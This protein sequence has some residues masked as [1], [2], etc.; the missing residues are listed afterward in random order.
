[1]FLLLLMASIFTVSRLFPDTMIEP[2]W[3]AT[4]T[5][6]IVGGFAGAVYIVFPNHC[7]A[8]EKAAVAFELC[9]VAVCT[10]QAVYFLLQRVGF[11]DSHVRNPAGSFDNVAGLVSCI[12]LSMPLGW[13]WVTT[14]SLPQR[15]ITKNVVIGIFGLCKL[16]GLV[17]VVLSESRTG[18]LCLLMISGMQLL[19]GR[20]MLLL[21]IV[22]VIIV[23]ALTMML[24]VKTESSYGRWFIVQR[25]AELIAE[26]PV[27]GW[28][29]GGFD[30]HYMDVQ[31]NFFAV[32]PDCKYAM[33]ADNVR[34]PLNEFLLV[35][36]DCGLA[37][38]SMV[39]L[40]AAFVIS[41]Y[42]RCPSQLGRTGMMV[43]AC[44]MVLS[45]F[46]YP[47]LYPFTWLMLIFALLCIFR[48][49]TVT[50][51]VACLSLLISLPVMAYGL[52]RRMLI[53]A[54]LHRIQE[55]ASYGLAHRMMPHYARLY[56]MMKDDYRF[57]YNYAAMQYEAGHYA[58]ALITAE[59]CSCYLTDYDL[60]LLLGDIHRELKNYDAAIVEYN[61]AH[62]MCPNRFEP[63]YNMV[64]VHKLCGNSDEARAIAVAIVRKEVKIPSVEVERIKQE[65]NALLRV[66]DKK[67]K[68]RIY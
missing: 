21:G 45:L 44:I 16:A 54:E 24:F 42:L 19:R 60:C 63:L 65:M 26:K 52:T 27:T 40:M 18:M 5:V 56:Q 13:R 64:L 31:A 37:G 6:G 61:R 66:V 11:V 8:K 28:G 15:S 43:L 35:A 68:S 51:R 34:H 38:L 1:M 55:K 17:A 32:H 23:L 7:L 46:S 25:T 36:V 58:G 59:E 12:C 22:P 67:H 49:R 9:C 29:L 47:F 62:L 33:L 48:I 20:R 50:V 39:L 3:Y 41:S 14:L 57:L 53:S 4:M 30:A 2:K 10:A